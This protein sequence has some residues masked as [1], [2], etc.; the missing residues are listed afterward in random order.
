M[1]SVEAEWRSNPDKRSSSVANCTGKGYRCYCSSF[2]G[3]SRMITAPLIWIELA[4]NGYAFRRTRHIISYRSIA[5]R[6]SEMRS[7]NDLQSAL[8]R[9]Q[10]LQGAVK[11]RLGCNFIVSWSSERPAVGLFGVSLA[12]GQKPWPGPGASFCASPITMLEMRG[13]WEERYQERKILRREDIEKEK[14]WERNTLWEAHTERGEHWEERTLRGD[15]IEKGR[16]LEGTTLREKYTEG[17]TLRGENMR[18]KDI[19]RDLQI[20]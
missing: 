20:R 5:A 1:A 14:Y 9:L 13:H 12:V 18:R 7:S 3:I 8:C 16:H 6:W 11:R 4:R 19:G 15:D 10:S 2:L 17:R